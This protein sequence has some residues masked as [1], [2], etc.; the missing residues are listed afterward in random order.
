MP[1]A[2]T[3]LAALLG[4]V[5]VAVALG[6]AA[7]PSAATSTGGDGA[8]A[9]SLDGQVGAGP[10]RLDRLARLSA[11]WRGG[12]ITTST[13]E[14]VSVLV[15]DSLPLETPEKWAEFMVGLV[16]GPEISR[17]TTSIASLAEVQDICGEQALGCYR[18]NEMIA[19]G[20]PTVDGTTPEEVVRH[21]YGH[22]VAFYRRNTP[23]DAIDWGPKRWASAAAV[24][25]KVSRS[26]AFPGDGGRNYAQNP[27]E[28]W[29]E[30]YRLMDER[31]AGITTASWLIIAPSFF[32][33]EAALVAAEQDVLH[34][35]TKNRV[36]T[37]G[38]TFRRGTRNAWWIPVQTPLD[39][40]LRL[41]AV[42]PRRSQHEVALVSA[43]RR[44]VLKRAQWVSQR[45][46]RTTT[47][48]CGQRSL[49]VRVLPNRSP[50]RI[51]ITLSTP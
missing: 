46:K 36:K 20:E 4:G 26:E 10:L 2:G 41:S 28:A 16:H 18:G 42:L 5:L 21:E 43:N 34:P 32:P 1:S 51:T 13:G 47:N 44:A 9:R 33:S 38:R 24:C 23:W 39:G 30:V 7:S 48:V 40:E 29:A 14:V 8:Y 27:G 3:R 19:L 50:G 15:S 11:T 12:A 17:L 49:F 25:P 45:L 35:W 22:H 6:G 37:F 31:K